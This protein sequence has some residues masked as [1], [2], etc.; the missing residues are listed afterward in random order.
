MNGYKWHVT[1][2]YPVDNRL[3]DRTGGRKL[4]TT[5]P[6]KHEICLSSDLKRDPVMLLRVLSH[7]L[8]HAVMIS[9][10]LLD[11][12]YHLVPPKNRVEMEEWICNFLADYGV[13]VFTIAYFILGVD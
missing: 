11:D 12:I 2:V 13:D 8:S 3:I 1:Y 6:N 4:A 10:H 9:Y 5:D 7:E